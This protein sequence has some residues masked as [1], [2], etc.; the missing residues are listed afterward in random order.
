M[1]TQNDDKPILTG[2]EITNTLEIIS[3][4][5]VGGD[6]WESLEKRKTASKWL[7]ETRCSVEYQ[8]A[9]NEKEAT[10]VSI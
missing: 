6:N 2:F 3:D 5:L 7:Q 8:E 1:A 10:I 9:G 4:A